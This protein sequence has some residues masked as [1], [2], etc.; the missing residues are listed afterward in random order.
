MPTSDMA[1]ALRGRYLV[2]LTTSWAVLLII[3]I[4]VWSDNSAIYGNILAEFIGGPQ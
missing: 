1:T 4:I 3:L 2:L